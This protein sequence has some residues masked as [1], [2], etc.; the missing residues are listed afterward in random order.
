[1]ND[2]EFAANRFPR[3]SVNRLFNLHAVNRDLL[4]SHMKD[5]EVIRQT[6]QHKVQSI[7]GKTNTHR[8]QQ[9]LEII[10]LEE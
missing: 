2:G 8:N 10:N 7:F 4:L 9:F 1:M 5:L 3:E 6:L